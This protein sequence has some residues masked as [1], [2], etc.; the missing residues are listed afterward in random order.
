MDEFEL[1]LKQ[2]FLSE[3]EDLLNQAEDVFLRLEGDSNN[4]DLLN[5]I[6]RL[7][8][9]LK[10]TSRAVG[11]EQ[12]AEL[13]HI[14]ENLILQLKEGD[15][16][17]T[18][19]VVS[20][21]LDFN[22]KV[23]EMIDTLKEDIEAKFDISEICTKLSEVGQESSEVDI[24]VEESE[25]VVKEDIVDEVPGST[26]SEEP[27]VSAAAI[28]SLRESGCSEEEIREMLGI[29]A[30]VEDNKVVEA[31]QQVVEVAPVENVAP[32]KKEK[33]KKSDKKAT[34]EDESI[35][36][37]LSR[38]NKLT[39]LVG[40]LV[41]IQ[42][43][44]G[45]R[46]YEF[47]HDDLTNKSIGQMSKLFKEIQEL[48]MSLR[49]LPLKTT[50]QK[51]NRIVRDTS[52]ALGKNVKLHLLGEETEVDKT[53]LEHLADPLVHMVRNAV[54]HG[55]ESPEDRI[56]AGKQEQGNVEI[57]AFHEGSNLVIQVTD[58]GKG[59]DP[60]MI[61]NK[62][63]AKNIISP[64]ANL[65]KHEIL[66]LVFHP[67]FSTKEQVSE[68]SGRGVGMDVVKSN[69]EQLGGEVKLMSKI[70]EGSSFKV[71]LP[72]T[73]AII[74][75]MVISV[76]DEKFVIPLGQ[77]NEL[78]LVNQ[79]DI[80]SFT[81]SVKLCRVRD[82]VF[83]L[84]HMNSKLS[85]KIVEQQNSTVIVVNGPGHTFGVIVDDVLNQQQIVIKK[86]GDD[87]RDTKG[88]MGSAIMGD[89]K[90]AFILDLYELFKDD[91]KKSRGFERILNQERLVG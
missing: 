85:Q 69:I 86:L 1:E 14:A 24:I 62:A 13:T 90:P 2:D 73:L 35:R 42:T 37:K 74:D 76:Q 57:M 21:L 66:Q 18:Q 45:Q 6:F 68:V 22:D 30:T 82:E 33:V 7:A 54:D 34:K 46:R 29:S 4:P 5:E 20:V 59:I 70:N 52:N 47:I 84:F 79:K 58:D 23:K 26:S 63:V 38:I 78:V 44:L 12:L 48:S 64:N 49:M 88:F 51:M 15:L 71:V 55:L 16:E 56:K 91:L 60:E 83:P 39:D 75:G 77:V 19:Q 31:E 41:I 61:R 27:E 17:P 25:V 28:E 53:V 9:N 80:E 43:V 87:I 8:H 11:F 32:L 36:V 50:F 40:E 81:Q 65:S 10:G 67:G 3:S 72:L 89:G